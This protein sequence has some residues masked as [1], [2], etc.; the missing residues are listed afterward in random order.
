MARV[1]RNM[2]TNV[3][4]EILALLKDIKGNLTISWKDWMPLIST[5]TGGFIA[6]MGSFG[7][8]FFQFHLSKK[9]EE[10]NRLRE[11]LETIGI[12]LNEFEK[13][14]RVD[15]AQMYAVAAANDT[16]IAPVHEK[17]QILL[18]NV[19][20]YHNNLSGQA[21][22]LEKSCLTYLNEKRDIKAKQIDVHMENIN[23]AFSQCLEAKKIMLECTVKEANHYK[24]N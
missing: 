15:I 2:E 10:R 12:L 23:A 5:V 1:I 19:K 17:L 3:E 14:L 6:L 4:T 20:L 21:C 16:N 22:D 11:K 7:V 24:F 8:Q 13:A 9:K 18:L